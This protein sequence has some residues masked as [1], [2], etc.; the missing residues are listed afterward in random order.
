MKKFL[1]VSYHMIRNSFVAFGVFTV[2]FIFMNYVLGISPTEFGKLEFSR[3][4]LM[5]VPVAIIIGIFATKPKKS[6]DK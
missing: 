6:N 2:A 4:F 1:T 5:Y 3:Q